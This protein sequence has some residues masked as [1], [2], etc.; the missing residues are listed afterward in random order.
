MS[1]TKIALYAG[2]VWVL[3]RVYQAQKYGV[4]ITDALTKF[5]VSVPQLAQASATPSTTTT[6]STLLTGQ[7]VKPPIVITMETTS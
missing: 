1:A 5:T 7:V 3:W 4:S 6:A 2:G